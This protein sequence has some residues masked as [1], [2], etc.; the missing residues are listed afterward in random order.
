MVLLVLLCVHLFCPPGELLIYQP[1][2]NIEKRFTALRVGV[3]RFAHAHAPYGEID[4]DVVAKLSV[5]KLVQIICVDRR[6]GFHGLYM[7]SFAKDVSS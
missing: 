2:E 5:T 1:A 4:G 7:V 6:G 3:R